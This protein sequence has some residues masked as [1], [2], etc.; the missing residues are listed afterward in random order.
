MRGDIIFSLFPLLTIFLY[1]VPVLFVI[2]FLLKILK[3]QKEKNSILKEIA[4]KLD[5]LDKPNL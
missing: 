5:K 1:G 2:W 4:N 3:L